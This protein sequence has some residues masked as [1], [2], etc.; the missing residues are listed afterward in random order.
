MKRMIVR[1]VRKRPVGSG[2]KSQQ[3]GIKLLNEEISSKFSPSMLD[4]GDISAPSQEIEAVT[5]VVDLSGFT[6]FCNQVD[7]YLA[8]PRFLND[9]L[10]WF[11][12][13]IRVGLTKE[14]EWGQRSFWTELPILVKFLGDGV[15]LLWN[16]R[17]MTN[18]VICKIVVTL[19]DICNAYRHQFYPRVSMAVDKPPTVLRCGMARGKVFTVGNGKDYVGHCINNASRLSQLRIVSF[20]FPHRGFPVQEYMPEEYRRLFVQKYLPIRGVGENELLWVVKE[21]YDKLSEKGKGLFNKSKL[22]GGSAW[23]SN[24]PKTSSMPPNGFEVREAHRD[25][26]AP[27]SR[28]VYITRTNGVMT[29][30]R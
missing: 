7:A 9:F 16:A 2:I 14:D 17:G 29:S 27:E 26:S 10:D 12:T 13:K 18:T 25:S 24:P 3:S 20:C 22:A 21:E 5:A 6:R 1:R 15:L 23:E 28:Q 19:Y 11:F 30:R 8:I 4:L